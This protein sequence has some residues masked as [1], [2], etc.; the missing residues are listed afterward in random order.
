MTFYTE[1]YCPVQKK[2]INS[3]EEIRIESNDRIVIESYHLDEG[4]KVKTMEIVNIRNK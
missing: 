3:R 2:V 4:T 1:C